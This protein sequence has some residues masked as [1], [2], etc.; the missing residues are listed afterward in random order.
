MWQRLIAVASATVGCTFALLTS[1][2]GWIPH[3][4]SMPFPWFL[5][6]TSACGLAFVLILMR[7][8]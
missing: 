8:R 5:A 1:T 3:F 6:V 4:T 7:E 2:W